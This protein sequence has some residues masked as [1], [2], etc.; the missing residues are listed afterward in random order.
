MNTKPKVEPIKVLKFSTNY[1]NTKSYNPGALLGALISGMGLKNDAALARVLMVP[2]SV[3]CKIRS[4]QMPVSDAMLVRIHDTTGIAIDDL[5]E[6]MGVK[7]PVLR[8]A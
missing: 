5:R 2:P 3:V 6:K 4:K 7:P 8:A 1:K